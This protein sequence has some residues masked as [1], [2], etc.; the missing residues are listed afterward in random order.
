MFGI[1]GFDPWTGIDGKYEGSN[2]R[3]MVLGEQQ[4][5]APLTDRECILRKLGGAH[6]L[7]FTNFDQAVL[8]CRQW[9]GGYREQVRAFWERTVF[10]NYNVAHASAKGGAPLSA[11]TRLDPLHPRLLRDMLRAFKPTHVIV[12]G[13]DN[14]RAIAVEGSSW[15]GEDHLRRGEIDEPWRR[16]VVDGHA[17]L[18]TRVTHP[19]ASFAYERWS[20]LLA[21]F[22]ALTP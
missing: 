7:I 20:V 13:G 22:L 1:D 6:D 2:P 16:I 8:G 10:Y 12:W 17:T 9:Q 19:S 21:R 4:L 3:V 14:W 5:D 18:F 15:E 11:Q